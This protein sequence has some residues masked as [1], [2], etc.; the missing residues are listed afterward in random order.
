MSRIRSTLPSQPEYWIKA[1]AETFFV[2]V[3][4]LLQPY[5]TKEMRRYKKAAMWLARECTGFSYPEL[6]RAFHRDD[7]TTIMHGVKEAG[8]DGFV[9][10]AIEEVLEYVEAERG[11]TAA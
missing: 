8:K 4:D 6:A 3:D 11:I 5:G 9:H 2:D 10:V 7:H 1:T